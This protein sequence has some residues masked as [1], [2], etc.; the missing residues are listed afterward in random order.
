MTCPVATV[1]LMP[2]RSRPLDGCL[3]LDAS[4]WVM[5][6]ELATGES[7]EFAELAAR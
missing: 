1:A 4:I 2:S 6:G 7:G 5:V 3:P